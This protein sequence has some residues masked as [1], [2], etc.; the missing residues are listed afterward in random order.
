MLSSHVQDVFDLPVEV[1]GA[2]GVGAYG[3]ATGSMAGP[4]AAVREALPGDGDELPRVPVRAE[5]EF[6]HARGLGV[7][8]LAVRQRTA[9]EGVAVE[10]HDVPG[11][12]V[13]AVV[14]LPRIA[15]GGAEVL[16]VGG[17]ARAPAFH[18][19]DG[20][21]GAGLVPPPRGVVAVDEVGDGRAAAQDVVADGEYLARNGI[22]DGRGRL[23]VSTVAARDI[24]RP[25]QHLP[26][27]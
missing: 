10:H 2:Y 16:D 5:G 13:V 23:I 6:Q 17:V 21:P 8:H 20:G 9:V 1:G 3:V 25:H 12:Q 26:C 11:P 18:V 19:P 24:A 7:M 22:E 15:R 4:G 27:G 14:E